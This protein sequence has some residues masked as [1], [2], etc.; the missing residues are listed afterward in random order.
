MWGRLALLCFLALLFLLAACEY[1]PCDRWDPRITCW[2]GPFVR[3]ARHLVLLEGEREFLVYDTAP[4]GCLVFDKSE[5]WPETADEPSTCFEFFQVRCDIPTGE[6]LGYYRKNLE[7][8]GWAENQEVTVR[9][10]ERNEQFILFEKGDH[11][12]ALHHYV[13]QG[14]EVFSLWRSPCEPDWEEH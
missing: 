7:R 10:P 9:V 11:M 3:P 2:F 5:Y 4:G 1:D 14:V 6:L 12:L 8:R 13:E